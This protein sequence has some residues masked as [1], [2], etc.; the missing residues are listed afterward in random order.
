M[1]NSIKR[2]FQKKKG[3][4]EFRKML[5]TPVP[6][7]KPINNISVPPHVVKPAP[8]ESKDNGIP[9]PPV[10]TPHSVPP[11]VSK[12]KMRVGSSHIH[13]D[14]PKFKEVSPPKVEKNVPRPPNYFSKIDNVRHDMMKSGIDPVPNGVIR[15]PIFVEVRDYKK[16]LGEI[17]RIKKDSAKS[18][19]LGIELDEI[20]IKKEKRL[21][22]W[23]LQ[24]EKMQKNLMLIDTIL[25]EGD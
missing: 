16:L 24:L 13:E 6:S 2:K 11:H 3:D 14:L 17:D 7:L 9:K 20:K 25:F 19:K 5:N 21:E 15:K 12:P 18:K 22:N 1:I 23:D 10:V 4:E 8:F